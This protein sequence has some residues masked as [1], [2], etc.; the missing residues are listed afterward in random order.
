MNKYI[1]FTFIFTISSLSLNLSAQQLPDASFE[2][3][4]DSFNGTPQL[5]KW[6]GS[7]V[8]QAGFKFVFI[9]KDAGRNGSCAKL[10]NKEVGAMGITREAPAYL[11]LGSPWSYLEGLTVSSATAGTDGGISFKYRP[12]SLA[13]WIKR[14]GAKATSEDYNIVYYSWKGTSS[15]S[16]YKNSGG[17]CTST[18]HTDEESDIRT[19]TNPNTC[20]TNTYATQIA[21]ARLN[22]KKV[23]NNW[24]EVKV[25]IKYYNDN[26]PEKMNIIF[27]A[28]NYPNGR[29]N[30]INAGNTLYVDDV[31]LIYS[32]AIHELYINN[33]K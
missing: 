24:T 5:A 29:S 11:T 19:S 15:A 4:S 33:F 32:S 23:Y 14:T 30:D 9:S 20:G 12:D 3:W 17:G 27:S 2:D 18:T 28:G 8:D 1:I 6:H 10:E 13:V 26:I 21:E 31:R 22:E 25:P 16:S 7:N